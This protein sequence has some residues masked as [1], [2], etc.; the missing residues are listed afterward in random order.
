MFKRAVHTLTNKMLAT[1][2]RFSIPCLFSLLF[3]VFIIAKTT[4]TEEGLSLLNSDKSILKAL[5]CGMFWFIALKLFAESMKWSLARYYAIGVVI[6]LALILQ[7]YFYKNSLVPFYF[8]GI[9]LFLSVFIAPFLNKKS[10]NDQIWTFNYY[11]WSH[12]CFT[13]LA[14]II[15]F[16]AVAFIPASLKFLFAVDFYEILYFY[17]W[18]VIAAFFSPIVAMAGIPNNYDSVEKD[19]PRALKIILS[20][21][22]LPILCIYSVILYG[23]II[24]ILVDWNLPKGGVVY[25]VSIFSS[26]S[27]IT[28]LVSYP[29]HNAPGIIKLFSRHFFKILLLP[30][31]LLAVAIEFRVSEYGL[32]EG[33]YTILLCLA[34]FAISSFFVLTKY[35]QEALK[36][37]FISIITLL[38]LASFGP[39][40]AV[41]ISSNSQIGRLK[42]LLEKNHLL[43][44]DQIQTSPQE[45]SLDDRVK[46]SSIIDYLVD[47]EK[48]EKLKV[49]FTNLPN[50]K[51]SNFQ[52]VKQIMSDLGVAYVSSNKYKDNFYFNTKKDSYIGIA[53]YD[54]LIET[55]FYSYNEMIKNIILDNG[56]LKLSIKLDP[57]TNHY[58][59]QM[60]ERNEI[61]FELNELVKQDNIDDLDDLV[62]EKK[63]SNLSAKLVVKRLSGSF[64]QDE[65]KP[66]I[67]SVDIIL[68]IKALN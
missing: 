6:F 4:D 63:T 5:F 53:G 60:N 66:V 38:I 10:S 8:L 65:H 43:V 49:W 25:L 55:S 28:Y 30:L 42:A 68:L 54:Y 17:I 35:R 62:L 33:R 19:Y 31:A 3:T 34:W 32:T 24:K 18:I 20:Y 51:D 29:L 21:I 56:R 50:A 11:L 52:G 16:I 39:W 67:S 15:L 61:V 46:I 7:L 40:G 48:S 9:G 1:I 26:I 64:D 2:V 22:I 47:T 13:I 23:Y 44:D 41:G 36:F 37:I 45:V 59:V 12:L 14:A 58:I 27:I 57:T